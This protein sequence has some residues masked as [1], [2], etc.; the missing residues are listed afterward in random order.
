MTRLE[1]PRLPD[2]QERDRDEGDPSWFQG[3]DRLILGRRGV[4]FRTVPEWKMSQDVVLTVYEKPTCTTCRKMVKLL[5]E[6]GVDFQRLNYFIDPLPRDK[7]VSLMKKTGLPPREFIRTR[8]KAYRE[9]GLNDK[10]L[11]DDLV[12]DALVE[13]PELLQRPILERGD[14]AVLGRPVEKVLE[15]L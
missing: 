2:I 8:E 1:V 3:G 11:P 6:R 10:S 12:I 7:L 13:H 14:R 4:L 9:L 15:L 5:T